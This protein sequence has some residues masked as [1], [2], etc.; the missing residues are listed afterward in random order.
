MSMITTTTA[1]DLDDSPAR[2]VLD[3]DR[4]PDKDNFVAVLQ[5][6]PTKGVVTLQDDGSFTYRTTKKKAKGTDTFTYVARDDTG[7]EATETVSIQI[8]GK[9]GK[10]HKKR[11]R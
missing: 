4:D 9:A 8:A 10:K 6:E 7:L 3:N 11:G 1:T 5:R 2:G